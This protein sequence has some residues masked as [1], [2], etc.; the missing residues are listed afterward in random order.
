MLINQ[1]TDK[2]ITNW[3]DFSIAGNERVSFHQPGTTSIALNRVIGNNLSMPTPMRRYSSGKLNVR[4]PI[5]I[6][7]KK[8]IDGQATTD[9]GKQ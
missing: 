7:I 1:H 2:L 8:T 9:I 5:E 3:N 6:H 4:R